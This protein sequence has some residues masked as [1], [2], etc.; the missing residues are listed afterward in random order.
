MQLPWMSAENVAVVWGASMT[1]AGLGQFVAPIVVG[2]SR[3]AFGTFVPGFMI[4]AVLAWSLLL[5]AITLND[6]SFTS[7]DPTSP[8]L[9]RTPT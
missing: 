4:W 3:D 8:E 7:S 6:A 5:A 2:A 1:I 9:E